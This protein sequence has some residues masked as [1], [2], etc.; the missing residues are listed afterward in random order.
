MK[1]IQIIEACGARV[2]GG[3]EYQWDCY[4]PNAR[5]MDFADTDGLEYCSVVHDSKTYEVYQ[6]DIHV[7]GY[8]QA[9]QWHEPKYLPRYLDECKARD[10]KPH[11]AWDD[12]VYQSV[13]EETILQYAKDVGETYYD[14]LP[15]PEST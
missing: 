9:F 5:Y 11:E 4:G 6:I 15:I 14:N 1:L 12:L 8:E 3:T 10:I 2:S 7:P 13:D